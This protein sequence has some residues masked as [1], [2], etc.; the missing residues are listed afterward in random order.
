MW[1]ISPQVNSPMTIHYFGQVS[2]T[3]C[4]C[5]SAKREARLIAFS[6]HGAIGV[7][8]RSTEARK[9]RVV[10]GEEAAGLAQLNIALLVLDSDYHSFK[11]QPV[12]ALQLL[13]LE[14]NLFGLVG[15]IESDYK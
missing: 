15:L 14:T 10:S 4:L 5:S 9:D 12:F 1:E 11:I 8:R 6:N 7:S 2:L 13:Q 3:A